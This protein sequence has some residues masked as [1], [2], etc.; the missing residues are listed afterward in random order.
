MNWIEYALIRAAADVA[1]IDK[2]EK[3][4]ELAIQADAGDTFSK[5]ALKELA[6]GVIREQVRKNEEHR[7]PQYR[8]A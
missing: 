3:M 2:V 1:P 8:V 7:R 5:C 6:H 4:V